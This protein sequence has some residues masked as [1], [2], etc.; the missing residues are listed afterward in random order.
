MSWGRLFQRVC[1]S[2]RRRRRN[3]KDEDLAAV[4][5]NF[6]TNESYKLRKTQTPNKS[7][8]RRSVLTWVFAKKIGEYNLWSFLRSH[9]ELGRLYEY[10]FLPGSENQ[11]KKGLDQMW[12]TR[13][14]N[15]DNAIECKSGGVLW[16]QS[17]KTS[18]GPPDSADGLVVYWKL[19][20]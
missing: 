11:P 17:S 7:Q 6:W 19:T 1:R 12:K 3:E 9:F 10:L 8:T 16:S 5:T 18:I 13:A 20:I 15:L 2:W 14:R 4:S